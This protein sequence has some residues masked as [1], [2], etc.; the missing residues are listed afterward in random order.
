MR[1]ALAL[2]EMSAGVASPNPPVGCVVVRDGR[3]LSKGWHEYRSRLHAE[4]NALA[5]A[6]TDVRGATAYVTLEPCVHYGRTP[7]CAAA[8]IAAG[9]RRVVVAREDPNPQVKGKGISAL[10]SAG[11]EVEVGLLQLEAG[12]VIEPFACHVITGVPLVVSKVGMS[13]D[14]RIAAGG[15]RS[16]RITSEASHEFSQRL[17]LQLD[18]LLVGIGTILVDDPRLSYRGK[19]PK[20]RPLIAVVLDSDLRTPPAARIF[21]ERPPEGSVLI[22]CRPDA[23]AARRGELQGKGACLIPVDHGSKGLDLRQVLRDLAA[24]DILGVLVEGGSRI[25]WSFVS[26]DLVDKFYFIMAPVVLGGDRAV[27]AVGGEGFA[28]VEAA[29]PYRITGEFRAGNDLILETYPKAS[30][31]FLSPWL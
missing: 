10:R 14:G 4:A 22:Y 16:D 25:H 15:D 21:Q 29:P 28:S 6:R 13:L 26:A 20:A 30:R 9:I 19:L 8:L 18:A 3:I 31:S 17:R 23:P 1:K 11:V 5:A 2:A 12:R 7:P 24:R 27:H